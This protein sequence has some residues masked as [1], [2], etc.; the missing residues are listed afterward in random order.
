MEGSHLPRWVFGTPC[1]KHIIGQGP[2]TYW[3]ELEAVQVSYTTHCPAALQQYHLSAV[4]E[5]QFC[6]CGDPGLFGK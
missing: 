2:G 6:T 3:K 5:A 4:Y 1:K